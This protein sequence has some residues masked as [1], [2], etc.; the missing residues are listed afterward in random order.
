MRSCSQVK[1]KRGKRAPCCFTT[2]SSAV[3]WILA[4]PCVAPMNWGTLAGVHLHSAPCSVWWACTRDEDEG[5]SAVIASNFPLLQ[6]QIGAKIFR[7]P[8]MGFSIHRLKEEEGG[9]KR[10][11]PTEWGLPHA[12]S[13]TQRRLVRIA[14]D[15][16]LYTSSCHRGSRVADQGFGRM[17]SR[18]AGCLSHQ[19]WTSY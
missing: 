4:F 9:G 6:R 15:H 5:W 3:N 1:S 17:N 2:N 10:S 16:R 8:F 14:L 7:T 18:T 19:V 12:T 11:L 13:H